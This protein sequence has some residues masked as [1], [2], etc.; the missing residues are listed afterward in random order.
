MRDAGE[1]AEAVVA[2]EERTNKKGVLSEGPKNERTKLNEN[3]KG[4]RESRPKR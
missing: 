3:L 4:N 1:S 2:I